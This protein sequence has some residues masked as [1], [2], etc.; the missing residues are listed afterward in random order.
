MYNEN[1]TVDVTLDA[2]LS[3]DVADSDDRRVHKIT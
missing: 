3:V 2:V 1:G